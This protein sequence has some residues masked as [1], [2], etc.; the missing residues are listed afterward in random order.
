MYTL[1][2][3]DDSPRST[4]PDIELYKECF[5]RIQK[6][7]F[8]LKLSDL[9]YENYIKCLMRAYALSL[10]VNFLEFRILMRY[11]LIK[12]GN[13]DKYPGM[14][15][16]WIENSMIIYYSLDVQELE[17][18]VRMKHI[19]LNQKLFPNILSLLRDRDNGQ[20][21]DAG[22]QYKIYMAYL[23]KSSRLN[24]S[25]EP[26]NMFYLYIND[27]L[28]SEKF[29]I[30]YKCHLIASNK[31]GNDID[32]YHVADGV[33]PSLFINREVVD[34]S[35]LYKNNVEIKITAEDIK[36]SLLCPV[37]DECTKSTME[38]LEEEDIKIDH[39]INVDG[40]ANCLKWKLY[41]TF[42]EDVGHECIKL[43]R[44][45]KIKINSNEKDFLQLANRIKLTVYQEAAKKITMPI[46]HESDVYLLIRESKWKILHKC[47]EEI[48]QFINKDTLKMSDIVKQ[49][50]QVSEEKNKKLA[51][52]YKDKRKKELKNE[53]RK[54]LAA[55]RNGRNKR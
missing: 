51:K 47:M 37:Y 7:P 38:L 16:V 44:N 19:A 29:Y 30:T 43:L 12:T 45:K 32:V 15:Q 8:E 39:T 48:G 50:R 36:E 18:L 34:N 53:L 31:I 2:I 42:V 54:K 22:K 3:P 13:Y 52:E 46:T 24:S 25:C 4:E 28:C 49:M 1:I 5:R 6:T 33:A 17:C 9:N 21:K 14:F 10:A 23:E 55:K 41:N 27:I 26:W 20:P 40:I 11:Y 35:K